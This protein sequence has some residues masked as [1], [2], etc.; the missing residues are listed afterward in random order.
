MKAINAGD[1]ICSDKNGKIFQVNT[2]ADLDRVHMGVITFRHQKNRQNG[3]QI[4]LLANT[5]FPKICAARSIANM[6]WR[7]K[8]LKHSKNLPLAIYCNAEKEVKYVTHAKVTEVIRRAVK[9]VHP[10]ISKEELMKYSCHSIRVWACVLLDEAGKSPDFIKKRLRW[11]G[12]SYHVYLRDTNK[13]REQHNEAPQA[14]SQNVMELINNINDDDVDHL[15]G[16]DESGEYD[17]GD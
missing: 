5:A 12:E 8:R 2:K 9:K 1:A 17:D 13:I 6:L 3:Q 11:M 7:K 14:S 15:S 16:R 10:D 4:R